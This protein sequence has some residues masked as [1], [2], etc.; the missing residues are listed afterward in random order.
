MPVRLP[1]ALLTAALAAGG[2]VTTTMPAAADIVQVGLNG[3]Y[4]HSYGAVAECTGVFEGGYYKMALLNRDEGSAWMT[5]GCNPSGDEDGLSAGSYGEPEKTV[6]LP[7]GTCTL[8]V[9]GTWNAEG[10]VFSS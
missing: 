9:Y 8:R 10:T 3:C 2:A 1:H 6:Y 5:I 4:A 7:T